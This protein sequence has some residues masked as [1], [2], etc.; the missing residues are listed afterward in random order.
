MRD[1]RLVALV[2]LT[3]VLSLGH[4]VDH[5][6]RGDLPLPPGLESLPFILASLAIYATLG[7]GLYLYSKGRVGPRFWALAGGIGVAF[8]WLAHFSPFTDQPPRYIV[9][10]YE[11]AAVGW[12]AVAWLVALMA[13]LV[14][15]AIYATW[16]W[17]TA[18]R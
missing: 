3:T 8:G 18:T 1:R 15:G 12:F 16:L 10:A 6:A 13:S 11:S 17:V 4:S 2:V 14:A 7:F 5:V 9:S